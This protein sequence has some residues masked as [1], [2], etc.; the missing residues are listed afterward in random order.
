MRLAM[1]WKALISTNPLVMHG[2]VCFTGTRIPVSVVLDNLA[3]GETPDLI[4][5]EYPSLS[6]E[7]IPAAMSYA[8]ELSRERI[9]AIPEQ[10]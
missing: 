5:N 3:A 8:A 10:G 1:N 9:V 4:L 6:A 7:H 2:A